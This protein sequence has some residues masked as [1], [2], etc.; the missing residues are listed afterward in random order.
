M[1]SPEA[2]SLEIF[3][4]EIDLDSELRGYAFTGRYWR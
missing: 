3:E 4:P 2:E 1:R